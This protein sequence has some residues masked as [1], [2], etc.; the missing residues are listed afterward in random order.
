MDASGSALDSIVLSGW[1]SCNDCISW[2][3]DGELAVAVGEYVHILTPKQVSSYGTQPDL[4]AIGLRQ[5]HST[6]LRTNVFTQRDWPD[7][8][9]APSD[10]FS[11]G[12]E[13]SLSTIVGLAWSPPGIG[14]H[15]RSLLAVLTSNHVLSLWESNGTVGE[16]KRVVVINQSLGDYFGWAE[17]AGEDIHRGQRRVRAF[18]WSPPYRFV[19]IGRGSAVTAKWGAIYLAVANDD[20]VVT[21]LRVSKWRRN[22]RMEWDVK[23]SCHIDPPVVSANGDPPYTGSLFQRAMMSKSPI[24][25]L[26]WSDL[27]DGSFDSSIQVTRRHRSNSIRVQASRPVTEEGAAYVAGHKLSAVY[28]DDS[29]HETSKCGSC[30]D[31]ASTNAALKKKI[32]KSRI[33][34][35]STHTLHGNSRVR[36]WGFA[37]SNS[38]DVA[39]IT[40]HP[41]DMVEYILPSMEKCALV[42]APRAEATDSA[43]PPLVTTTN[44]TD[45]LHRLTTWILSAANELSLTLAIDR[46]LL[47]ISASYATRSENEMVRQKAQ[48]GLIR[49]HETP[50]SHLDQDE[51][52]IDD[53]V[54]TDSL[55]SS[56]IEMCLICEARIPFDENNL[57]RARCETGHQCSMLY[58]EALL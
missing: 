6:R 7:Q 57:G 42:F 29:K 11:I 14:P 58:N 9:P 41:T 30:A 51:M 8:L 39:C 13:Q 53:P 12:E 16:W 33:E 47:G 15:R 45:V 25:S 44:P 56:D 49:L 23:A 24:W 35:D 1:P 20:E 40:V 18:T 21:I 22:G 46:R 36:P 38:Q 50:K 26:S 54:Q 27:Q 10:T 31:H 2:S 52:D 19:Q 55:T 48:T 32:E 28:D 34:F 3:S 43:Q 17:K 37:S 5:W 4:A